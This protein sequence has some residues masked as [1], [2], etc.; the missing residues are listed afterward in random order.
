MLFPYLHKVRF[1]DC[2]A[3]FHPLTFDVVFCKDG[4]SEEEL[5][6]FLEQKGIEGHWLV[7]DDFSYDRYIDSFLASSTYG[8]IDIRTLKMFTTTLCN[9]ACDYC[10]IEKNLE[11]RGHHCHNI[12]REDAFHV[13]D[14]FSALCLDQKP[15]KR[16]IM[17]YGGE[18][19]MNRDTLFAL[20]RKIRAMEKED[21]FHGPVEIDLEC[22]GTLVS[23]EDAEFLKEHDVFILISLD[24]IESVH[25]TYRRTKQGEGSYQDA[26]RGFETLIRHGCT[27]VIS[28]VF[29]DQYAEHLDECLKAMTDDIKPK[30]IGLN[31]FHVL[32]DQD[33]VNDETKDHIGEYLQAFEKAR[34]KGLYIEHIMRRIRPLTDRKIRISDCGACGNRIVSDVDGNIGICEGLVGDASYF[35]PREDLREVRRDPEFQKWSV[36]T[37]LKMKGCI[38]CKAMGICGGGCVSNALRQNNDLYSPDNYICESSKAFIDYAMNQWHTA[39]EETMAE[40]GEK[41]HLL[42]QKERDTLLGSLKKEYDIPLQTVSKQ[43]EKKIDL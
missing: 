43:F 16:T 1:E 39:A 22:N 12:S 31:L 40:S 27:A 18:P 34:E 19:L 9:L 17:L 14:R 2:T 23:D 41:I 38:G 5:N 25:N 11:M 26:R 37:P 13:I 30:S 36:R 7:P 8:E 21:L 6:A 42:T 29:T 32:E 15:A 3:L 33:I 28:S 4:T 35:F 10:L 20:I 24:G